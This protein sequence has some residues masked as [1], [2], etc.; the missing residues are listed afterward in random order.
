MT[1]GFIRDW[2][3]GVTRGSGGIPTGLCFREVG[4]DI[5]VMT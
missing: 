4:L 5:D 3:G 2:G 1:Q